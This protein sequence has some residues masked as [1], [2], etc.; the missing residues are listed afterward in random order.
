M[1]QGFAKAIVALLLAG[2]VFLIAVRGNA[3]LLDMS[4]LIGMFCL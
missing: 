3:M 2:G 4:G 1:W